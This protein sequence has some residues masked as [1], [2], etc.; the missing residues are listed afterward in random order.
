MTLIF[1]SSPHYLKFLRDGLEIGR[2]QLV[3][4][5]VQVHDVP[6]GLGVDVLN[7]H[8]AAD[9]LIDGLPI[10][11]VQNVEVLLVPVHHAQVH[12]IAEFIQLG[13]IGAPHERTQSVYVLELQV[14]PLLVAGRPGLQAHFVVQGCKFR[15]VA[16]RFLMG[17]PRGLLGQ[18]GLCHVLLPLG[19][20]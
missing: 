6:E 18:G 11:I 13:H 4:V 3:L 20:G 14:R 5:L 16:A 10:Q 9:V 12:E 1:H 8:F 2:I 19:K 7:R 17:L 15:H